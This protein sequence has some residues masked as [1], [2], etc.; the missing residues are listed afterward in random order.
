MGAPSTTTSMK[1][2]V[3]APSAPLKSSVTNLRRAGR[4]IKQA[5][6]ACSPSGLQRARRGARGVA[7][8]VNKLVRRRGGQQPGPE[9][10]HDGSVGSLQAHAL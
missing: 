1:H 7:E 6:P 10:L 9:S 8:A 5:T 3:N 2:G 4:C